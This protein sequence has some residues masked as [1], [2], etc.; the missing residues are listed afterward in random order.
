MWFKKVTGS[1]SESA[2]PESVVNSPWTLW[3]CGWYSELDYHQLSVTM[4]RYTDGSMH[5]SVLDLSGNAHADNCPLW[6]VLW[7]LAVCK[8]VW[9]QRSSSIGNLW[10]HCSQALKGLASG[11][12]PHAAPNCF[13]SFFY[14]WHNPD[15]G[16]WMQVNGQPPMRICWSI[17]INLHKI[18]IGGWSSA[19]V[20]T[21]F[22][23]H[24]RHSHTDQSVIL[25]KL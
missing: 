22:Q 11:A 4:I 16:L 24:K 25:L 9:M 7:R 21:L 13:V 23:L 14:L 20:Q 5:I 18:I 1:A 3:G 15:K 8:S 10:M 2:Y 17:S 12:S 6:R 19:E